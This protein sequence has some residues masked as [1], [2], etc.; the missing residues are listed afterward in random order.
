MVFSDKKGFGEFHSSDESIA[1]NILTDRLNRLEEF[2]IITKSRDP[3]HQKK[4]IYHLTSKGVDLVPILLEMIKW[5][6]KYDSKTLAPRDFVK[7]LNAFKSPIAEMMQ[8]KLS[9]K[10]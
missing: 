7:E 8:K 5:G 4:F 6:A 10:K 3:N 1:T 9:Q 2:G